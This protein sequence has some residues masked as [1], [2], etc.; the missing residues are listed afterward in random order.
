[1]LAAENFFAVRQPFF[2][3]FYPVIDAFSWTQGNTITT[4]KWCK[5]SNCRRV[6]FAF[7]TIQLG[8]SAKK[9]RK[10]ETLVLSRQLA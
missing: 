7:N 1:M 4:Q 6:L 8:R 5:I 3:A 9:R 10:L 2:G